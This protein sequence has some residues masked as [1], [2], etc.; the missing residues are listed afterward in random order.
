[1]TILSSVQII[2]LQFLAEEDEDESGASPGG[3]SEA[4]GGSW[5]RGD[6]ILLAVA[7]GDE[8]EK[9]EEVAGRGGREGR[10]DGLVAARVWKERIRRRGSKS[11]A[12]VERGDVDSEV[13][14]SRV[15]EDD[16]GSSVSTEPVRGLLGLKERGDREVGWN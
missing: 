9:G 5:R 1:M 12:V 7:L 15:E 3:V 10:W 4:R 2:P 13:H 14:V 8:E 16:K 11:C 6:A